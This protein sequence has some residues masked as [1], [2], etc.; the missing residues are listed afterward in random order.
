MTFKELF[1]L[2][3]TDLTEKGIVIETTGSPKKGALIEL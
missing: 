1:P 2:L 3:L